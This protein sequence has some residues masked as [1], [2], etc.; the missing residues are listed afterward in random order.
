MNSQNI[1]KF[2]GSNL[3]LSLDSSQ[4][5]D[6]EIY[7]TD[8]DYDSQVLD[9]NKPI[10]YDSLSINTTGLTNTDCF[11]NTIT[12]NEYDNSIN[13]PN[14]VYSGL[15]WTLTYSDF[16]NTL[17][18]SDL[19]LQ[20]DVYEFTASGNTHYFIINGYNS[21]IFNPF[22]LS[23]I[24]FGLGVTGKSYNCVEQ[25]SNN[26]NCCPQDLISN[27]KPW[28]YQ[29]NHGGGD[30]NCDYIVK[31]RNQKGWTIDLVLNKEGRPW[32]DG[33]MIYYLGV[34]N[35]N[36][37][38][39]YADNNLSF[40]FTDDGRI[41]WRTIRYSGVCLTE[42]GYTESFYVSSGQTPVLCNNGTS[43]D[44]NITI[45]FE[46]EKYYLDC[47]LENK[48]GWNDLITGKTLTT[49]IKDW[50]TGSTPTY[51]IIETLNKKWFNESNRRLG[52]LKIYLNGRTI[53]KIKNWEEIIPSDRG[54]Q[55][56]IQSWAGGTEFSG[57]IHNKGISCFNF[58]RIK[59]FEEPLNFVRVRHH[60]LVNTKPNYLINE[61]NVDCVEQVSKFITHTQTPTPTPT[62]TPNS[63]LLQENLSFILQENGDKITINN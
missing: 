45:A 15:T 36:D 19:I 4:F 34:R 20:N 55:P 23:T 44:F 59:F 53:Y 42:S 46:R 7:K 41:E 40:S 30:N 32:S 51:E 9:L 62:P 57:G 26:D 39:N 29:I 50:L 43:S 63:N 21:G 1:L 8:L 6:Y 22:S 37:V 61:C 11:R 5:H 27:A 47:D 56:F 49:L 33:K 13:N 17:N 12:L 24:G 10:I 16:T 2:W 54:Y 35:E 31:R 60:Y 25:I 58:K 52:T 38:K 48:G 14:Y 18:N 3:D 28:A